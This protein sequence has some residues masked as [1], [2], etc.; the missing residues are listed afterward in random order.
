[1]A[2][3]TSIV[4]LSKEWFLISHDFWHATAFWGAWAIIC[5]IC[6]D[7]WT[8]W[9]A[10]RGQEWYDLTY[11]PLNEKV[12]KIFKSL[13][14]YS[15]RPSVAA[16][17]A[18]LRPYLQDLKQRAY[19]KDR[20]D[21]I[22]QAN[23]SAAEKLMQKVKEEQGTRNQVLAGFKE[24]TFQASMDFY[25]GPDAQK[26]YMDAALKLLA[27]NSELKPGVAE[28]K[29]ISSEFKDKYS[30]L[31][32]ETEKKYFD[33]RRKSSNLPWVMATD[34]EIKSAKMAPADKQKRYADK[35]AAFAKKYH[36]V[37]LSKN[38]A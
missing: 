17:L 32:S 11:F 7:W 13:E 22:A 27:A 12:N 8:W 20:S 25:N 30:S 16:S 38:F 18:T 29:S 37:Q 24:K 5:T 19:D 26:K 3:A 2:G 33:E 1:M 15:A 34:A 10:L 4:L 36:A 21:M 9:Y 14:S 28:A 35:V 23:I 31:Y 6:V